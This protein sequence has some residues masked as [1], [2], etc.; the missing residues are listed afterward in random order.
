[1]CLFY[2]ASNFVELEKIVVRGKVADCFPPY[3]SSAKQ[4]WI[5]KSGWGAGTSLDIIDPFFICPIIIKASGPVYYII[6][7]FVCL[8]YINIICF[9][10]VVCLHSYTLTCLFA[11]GWSPLLERWPWRHPG[12]WRSTLE[13]E[14]LQRTAGKTSSCSPQRE[15]CVGLTPSKSVVVYVECVKDLTKTALL[16][17]GQCKVTQPA[18]LFFQQWDSSVLGVLH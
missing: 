14:I 2:N 6:F 5:I 9:R 1:M 7:L 17:K 4:I 8:M 13:W 18:C 10:V 11:S 15:R 12:A 16:I 3:F